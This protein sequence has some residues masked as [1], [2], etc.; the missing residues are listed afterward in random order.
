MFFY[1]IEKY[2]QNQFPTSS[3]VFGAAIF[4]AVARSSIV[5]QNSVFAS[6]IVVAAPRLLEAAA[7]CVTLLSFAAGHRK[8]YWCGCI[9]AAI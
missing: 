8:S 4:D 2:W 3:S 9:K 1:S 7:A 5:F 6:R